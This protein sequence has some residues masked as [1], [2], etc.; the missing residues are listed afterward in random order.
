[1]CPSPENADTPFSVLS[2]RPSS[3]R[4]VLGLDL[5]AI[6]CFGL[7]YKAACSQQDSAI[8]TGYVCQHDSSLQDSTPP[9][10]PTTICTLSC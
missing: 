6:T 3:V 10:G 2:P 9:R 5:N 8:Q 1:M 4:P 7:A